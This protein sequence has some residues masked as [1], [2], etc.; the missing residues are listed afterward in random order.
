MKAPLVLLVIVS[1]IVSIYIF[2]KKT[3]PITIA[4]PIILGIIILLYF[5]AD[6]KIKENEVSYN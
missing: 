5:L 1:F 2:I 4:T 3:Y 6:L